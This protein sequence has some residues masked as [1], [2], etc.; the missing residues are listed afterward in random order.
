M[1]PHEAKHIE[2]YLMDAV[3]RLKQNRRENP[4]KWAELEAQAK[5]DSDPA[6]D[7][8]QNILG[9][10]IYPRPED[11]EIIK[12]ALEL[13]VQTE[14]RLTQ[15]LG[16][17]LRAEEKRILAGCSQALQDAI[18]QK[19][20]LRIASM[21]D[22]GWKIRREFQ[23]LLHKHPSHYEIVGR[24]ETTLGPIRDQSAPDAPP[25]FVRWIRAMKPGEDL[26][27]VLRKRGWPADLVVQTKPMAP[28]RIPII[29]EIEPA[30]L[31]QHGEPR[32]DTRKTH[33]AP[34]SMR[35]VITRKIRIASH[36]LRYRFAV[37]QMVKLHG[38][39]A[40]AK[41]TA[42]TRQKNVEK[43][44]RQW[45]Q[46]LARQLPRP[47]RQAAIAFYTGRHPSVDETAE[48]TASRTDE[49]D[50]TVAYRQFTDAAGYDHDMTIEQHL[51][52]ALKNPEQRQAILQSPHPIW[53]IIPHQQKL[54]IIDLKKTA[55]ALQNRP[56][57]ILKAYAAAPVVRVEYQPRYKR[58]TSARVSW[59]NE[60]RVSV[61]PA[62]LIS[63]EKLRQ[64]RM[65]REL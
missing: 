46:D 30:G 23:D 4:K 19:A 59:Q 17:K 34:R 7:E 41:K 22:R 6:W 57:T 21:S 18:V 56:G 16:R 39:Q 53:W 5:P 55:E 11:R 8:I 24:G 44:L 54:H 52:D 65:M 45:T 51:Y 43:T 31:V 42:R 36:A 38:Q 20:R 47:S 61:E 9:D 26:N 35:P 29:V 3:E 40:T 13:H 14:T 2:Q 63:L 50:V 27:E 62:T 60:R 25:N 15:R 10:A 48:F 64:R 12:T 1:L 28:H 37:A 49:R 33:E 58:K 32:E